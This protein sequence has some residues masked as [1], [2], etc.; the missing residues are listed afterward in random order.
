M[1]RKMT[2]DDALYVGRNMR[3]SD[4]KEVMATR[5]N[6]DPDSFALECYRHEGWTALADGVPVAIAGIA[7]HQPMVGQAWMVGTKDIKKSGLTITRAIRTALNELT[8]ES[9]NRIQA[10]SSESHTDA[11][12]WLELIG[13][14]LERDLPM[15]GKHGETF[16]LYSK[17]I[18]R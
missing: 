16:L 2:L 7:I 11:H 18:E 13:M 1:I 14:T 8:K 9:L 10:F 4:F 15:Y 3:E 17:T 6:D 12:E 5:W